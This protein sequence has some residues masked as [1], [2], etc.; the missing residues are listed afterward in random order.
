M[1]NKRFVCIFPFKN[2]DLHVQVLTSVLCV[3]LELSIRQLCQ[4]GLLLGCSYTS[5][6]TISRSRNLR[7]ILLMYPIRTKWASQSCLHGNT[8]NWKIVC[9]F[10]NT[11]NLD[12]TVLFR[13]FQRGLCTITYHH[14]TY[15]FLLT[16][17]NRAIFFGTLTG[18]MCVFTC[19]FSNYKPK[20][21]WL[22]T[23]NI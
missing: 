3:D 6:L 1:R 17:C 5:R 7:L 4:Y 16:K 22:V 15:F 2:N 10:K 23:K 11:T 8:Y 14:K 13:V 18:T 21:V 19:I 20:K 9:M 12:R